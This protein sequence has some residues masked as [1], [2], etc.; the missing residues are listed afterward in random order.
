MDTF[1]QLTL[2]PALQR[3]IKDLG[4]E[5][6]S[7]IQAQA[8]PILLGAKTDFIGLAATGTGKTAAFSLPLLQTIDPHKRSVQALILCPT[9]ELSLQ[10]AGQVDLLGKHLGVRALPIYGGSGYDDQLRGLK[11]GVPVVVGT[12]GR[13]IDHMER[14]T[15]R[16]DQ[17]RTVVLDEA[18]EMISMG[19]REAMETILR[20]VPREQSNTW[21]FSATMSGAVRRVADEFLRGPK[22]V[23]VNRTEM[24]ASGIEQY[25][26][27]TQ[28]KNKPEV[29]CKLIEAAEDFYGVVF[30]QTKNLVV[31]L[32]RYLSERG[33]KADSLHGDMS[34]SA[35]ESAMLAFRERRV[36]VLVCTDVASRGLDV[37]DITHVVNYSI[38]RE[39][40]SYVHRIGRTARSGKTGIAMS[41]V[42]PSHRHLISKIERM[43]GSRLNEGTIPTRKAIGLKKIS[44][45]LGPFNDQ[46][47]QER[48]RELMGDAW[49]TAVTDMSAEDVAARFLSL[50]FPYVFAEKAQP[51]M[52]RQ[53]A[54]ATAAADS[55]PPRRHERGERSNDSKVERRDEKRRAKRDFHKKFSKGFHKGP[56]KNMGGDAPPRRRP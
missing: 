31:D 30:C 10:V 14:G 39:L 47:G 45:L 3:A 34:Q 38:P 40:D 37:K 29:L 53:K 11:K 36:R 17:V 43:T 22:S 28:E 55:R 27:M 23:Q 48:A 54:E 41:L 8:L 42:T 16:L 46:T 21:L 20:E 15:L 33:Y 6:P 5:K 13:V 56:R 4:Y 50:M 12:P 32:T 35:R 19:F 51:T 44:Q 49:K 24:L 52:N 1:D 7:A 18:D 25:F 2:H 26:Y 9:R